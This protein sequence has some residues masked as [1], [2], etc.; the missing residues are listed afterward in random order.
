MLMS[1]INSFPG[2]VNSRT[3]NEKK[4]ALL[5][6]PQSHDRVTEFSSVCKQVVGNFRKPKQCQNYI[7]SKAEGMV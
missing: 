6:L 1:F 5:Q 2:V 7:G 4:L 3:G